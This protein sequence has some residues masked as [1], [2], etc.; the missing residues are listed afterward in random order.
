[1]IP[2]QPLGSVA[3]HVLLVGEGAEDDVP[4]RLEPFC[5]RAK[6]RREHHRDAALH[7]QGAPAPDVTVALDAFEGWLA[8]LL[9][10]RRDDVHVSVEKKRWSRAPAAEASD[11]V[12]PVGI[13]REDRRVEPSFMQETVDER[14]ALPLVAGRIRRVEAE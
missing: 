2:H 12:G 9:P 1:V 5:S 14:D 3:A 11:Q 10:G 8:P 7:V 13:A 6:Q 4:G